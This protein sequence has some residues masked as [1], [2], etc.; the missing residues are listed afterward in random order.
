MGNNSL[1]KVPPEGKKITWQKIIGK[2]YVT[3][4]TNY[5]NLYKLNIEIDKNQKIIFFP[6][7][8]YSLL[9]L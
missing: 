6:E 8:F 9:K 3:N 1:E 7:L 5:I 4:N 2:N